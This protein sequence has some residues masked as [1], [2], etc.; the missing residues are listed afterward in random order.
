MTVL[1]PSNV[2][3]QS[4]RE[5]VS[6]QPPRLAVSKHG[7]LSKTPQQLTFILCDDCDKLGLMFRKRADKL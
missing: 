1:V 3:E 5:E 4:C 7:R 2:N 6:R